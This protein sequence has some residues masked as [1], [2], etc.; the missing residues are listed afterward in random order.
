MMKKSKW[1]ILNIFFAI[2]LNF[3][4]LSC[5]TDATDKRYFINR[6]FTTDRAEYWY[7][8]P[9]D[10]FSPYPYRYGHYYRHYFFHYPQE[11]KSPYQNLKVNPAGE[12]YITVRPIHAKV[13]VDGYELKRRGNGS[14]YIVGLLTGTHSIEVRAE[15]YQPYIKEVEIK[16]GK[17]NFISVELKNK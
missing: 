14:S 16:R 17:R 4:I 2:F 9:E 1:L 3:L 8:I 10:F 13:F 15:G 7:I 6:Y 11:E 12:I 5:K